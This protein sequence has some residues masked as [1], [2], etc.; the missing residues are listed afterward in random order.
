MKKV[1]TTAD[2]KVLAF[3]KMDVVLAST[4]DPYEGELD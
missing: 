1:Y 2:V 4:N 3:D